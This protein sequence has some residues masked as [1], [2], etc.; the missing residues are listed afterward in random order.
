MGMFM[1]LQLISYE[2]VGLIELH[3][4]YDGIRVCFP[5]ALSTSIF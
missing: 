1:Q 4:G 2:S 5:N 3:S